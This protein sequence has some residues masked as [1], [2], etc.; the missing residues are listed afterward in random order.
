[1]KFLQFVYSFIFAAICASIGGLF[2][3]LL[4]EYNPAID[5]ANLHFLASLCYQIMVLFMLLIG[6]T[7]PYI[8]RLFKEKKHLRVLS[9]FSVIL[10]LSSSIFQNTTNYKV[11]YIWMEGAWLVLMIYICFSVKAKPISRLLRNSAVVQ[12]LLAIPHILLKHSHFYSLVII[13]YEI[14]FLVSCVF[15][16]LLI[17][18]TFKRLSDEKV[19][20]DSLKEIQSI[21]LRVI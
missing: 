17:K 12:A 18:I 11:T 2:L 8:L 9:Y 5:S 1:M 14:P 3:G 7:F 13:C 6:F 10:T 16:L 19:M 4:V 20:Q 21:A 15:N